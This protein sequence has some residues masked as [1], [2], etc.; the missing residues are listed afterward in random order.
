MSESRFLEIQPASTRGTLMTALLP[1]L[2][3]AG[4]ACSEARVAGIFGHSFTF[5]MARAG[6]EVWQLA[7]IEWCFFFREL[8]LLPLRFVSFDAV[9]RGGRPAPTPEELRQMKER[10]WTQVV[11]GI[12]RGVPSIAW[13]AMTLEQRESGIPGFEWNLLVGYDERSRTYRVRHLPHEGSWDVPF[14]GFGYCDPVQWYH[15]MTPGEEQAVD[16]VALKTRALSQSIEYAEGKR[17]DPPSGCNPVDAIGF[18]AYE[19]WKESILQGS[20]HPRNQ[21]AHAS[22]L[23]WARTQAATFVRELGLPETAEHYDAEVQALRR[24][25]EICR[26]ASERG[27]LQHSEIWEAARVLDDALL[28]ERKAIHRLSASIP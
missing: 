17:F 15:V 13:G 28:A 6:G 5:S 23:A 19:L 10:T 1:T 11:A 18:S 25:E 4:L 16:G 9:L 7:N 14:D 21:L 8:D 12:D 22:Y 20:A 3:A 24:L 26:I 2:G 27:K